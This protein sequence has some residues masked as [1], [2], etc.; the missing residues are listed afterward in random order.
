M[1]IIRVLIADDH[2]VVR[3]GLVLVL[4]QEPEIEVIGEA[5][6]GETAVIVAANNA[7]IKDPILNFGSM[8]G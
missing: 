7:K 6:N 1:S 4:G 5:E 3:R 8:Q 2:Q